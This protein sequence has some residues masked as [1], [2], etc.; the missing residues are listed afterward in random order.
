MIDN[1]KY[2]ETIGLLHQILSSVNAEQLRSIAKMPNISSNFRD[3]LLCLAKEH[4]NTRSLLS[5]DKK[6]NITETSKRLGQQRPIKTNPNYKESLQLIDQLL[7]D[8]KRFPDK[9]SLITFSNQIGLSIQ[10]NSKE[11]KRDLIRK[12]R[13]RLS[14][15]PQTTI[16]HVLGL[17]SSEA[18]KQT[19][20]WFS[21]IRET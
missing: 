14:T 19:L 17:L 1:K 15:A 10:V 3:A 7:N 5:S 6:S 13:I 2:Y 16:E 20:G 4:E 11:G 21:L 18:D 9:T 8:I 12:I